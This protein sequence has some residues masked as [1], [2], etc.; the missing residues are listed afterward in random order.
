[1]PGPTRGHGCAWNS[2]LRD[3]GCAQP[4]AARARAPARSASPLAAGQ[5]ATR[6]VGPSVWRRCA[7]GPWALPVVLCVQAVLSLRLI[8]VNTAFQ[9][10][11][12][13]L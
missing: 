1:M 13:Y 2:S 9:D 11:A 3:H 8:R 4:R 7:G 6:T 5:P 12:L 10:E